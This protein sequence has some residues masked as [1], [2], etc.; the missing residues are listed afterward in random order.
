MPASCPGI[1]DIAGHYY[2]SVHPRENAAISWP[3]RST[4]LASQS[5]TRTWKRSTYH[6]SQ[7]VSVVPC[8]EGEYWPREPRPEVFLLSG[9]NWGA[10]TRRHCRLLVTIP[11]WRIVL[12]VD[13]V[14]VVWF[15]AQVCAFLVEG[16]DNTR[17][18]LVHSILY[19][20]V[21][22][23]HSQA[24]DESSKKRMDCS[25]AKNK[26]EVVSWAPPPVVDEEVLV[27]NQVANLGGAI[28]LCVTKATYR[29]PPR[30]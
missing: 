18:S 30:V 14:A 9:K 2:Y 23:L 17:I 28:E 7:R 25:D 1:L 13:S 27:P 20:V 3:T 10:R 19:H 24:R 22:V 12:S 11:P 21:P 16:P 8:R 29:P 15:L 4:T 26:A 5:C 6:T